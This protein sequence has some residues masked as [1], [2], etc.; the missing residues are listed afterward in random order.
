MEHERRC[1]S[2]MCSMGAFSVCPNCGWSYG[3]E[4]NDTY[5]LRAGTVLRGR[6]QIGKVKIQE[7]G[8]I[9]YY[10]WDSGTMKRVEVREYYPASLARRVAGVPEV[11][12]YDD[13]E[14]RA[15]FNEGKKNFIRIS[16]ILRKLSPGPGIVNVLDCFE[17]NSTAY[18]VTEYLEG[19]S[20]GAFVRQGFGSMTAAD[21]LNIARPLCEALDFL[22]KKGLLIRSLNPDSIILTVDNRVKIANFDEAVHEKDKAKRILSPELYKGYMAPELRGK[23]AKASNRSDIYSLCSVL[24]YVLTGSNVTEQEITGSMGEIYSPAS[25]GKLIP[26]SM[27][28][29]LM[30][31]LASEPDLRFRSCAALFDALSGKVLVKTV[32]SSRKSSRRK[33]SVAVLAAALGTAL[34][35]SLFFVYSVVLGGIFDDDI[36]IWLPEF[37][38][39]QRSQSMHQI[40]DPYGAKVDSVCA[41]FL[42]EHS[43]VGLS[44]EWIPEAEYRQRILSACADDALP[45]LFYSFDMLPELE[46]RIKDVGPLLR[47]LSG[48]GNCGILERYAESF[49][50]AAYL[51]TAMDLPVLYTNTALLR[52]AQLELPESAALD[53]YMELLGVGAET[54]QR[55]AVHDSFAFVLDSDLTDGT[56]SLPEALAELPV[57]FEQIE[58]SFPQ[59]SAGGDLRHDGLVYGSEELC[60]FVGSISRLSWVQQALPGY[61]GTGCLEDAALKFTGFFC[62]SESTAN[63]EK[64]AKDI[65]LRL[66]D[67]GTQVLLNISGSGLIPVEDQAL[68]QYPDIYTDF[69]HIEEH[70]STGAVVGEEWYA[71]IRDNY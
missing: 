55:M 1:M 46:G 38:D 33:K 29:A 58:R 25:L 7:A 63:K 69:D 24:Y 41:S 47:Y 22:H 23:K 3:A 12:T 53:T 39:S 56:A 10:A 52:D 17:D 65:V 4:I 18:A 43:N 36:E 11:V 32:A 27:D 40:F 2:C 19:I 15:R 68:A 14:R 9:T 45:E 57:G 35:V 59:T 48:R 26:E 28:L 51:P 34:V 16:G 49:P 62:I 70:I 8:T 54:A 6:Y 42:E 30:K 13:Q 66:F 60:C 67:K 31:G 21:V 50:E 20:L 44:V 61:Y 71:Y 37:E 5:Q 64:I